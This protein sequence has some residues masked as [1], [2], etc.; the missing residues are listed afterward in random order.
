M[1]VLV[2]AHQNEPVVSRMLPNREIGGAK[3][4]DIANMSRT[5]IDIAQGGN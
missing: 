4:A 5:R 3:Q 2:L 1:K